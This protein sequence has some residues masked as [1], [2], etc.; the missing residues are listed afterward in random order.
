M[1]EPNKDPDGNTSHEPLAVDRYDKALHLLSHD[2]DNFWQAF[3]AFLL[4]HTVLVGFLL[5]SPSSIPTVKWRPGAFMGSFLG[6]L[7]CVP[8]LASVDRLRTYY[9]LRV[10]Q[11]KA[12]E[13]PG[14]NL[15]AGAG[16]SLWVGKE[17]VVGDQRLRMPLLA[18]VLRSTPVLK[19]FIIAFVACYL[20]VAVL[21]A[22]L[23]K[24]GAV[25]GPPWH[26]AVQRRAPNTALQPTAGNGGAVVESG[27]PEVAGSR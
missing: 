1:S 2:H 27:K 15:I 13:P 22:P 24:N 11:A 26:V 4:A 25:A 14:W 6:L 21:S 9:L 19:L 23:R 10:A 20:T 17:V 3:G 7:L 16:E 5:Q 12:A 8:W 18:R